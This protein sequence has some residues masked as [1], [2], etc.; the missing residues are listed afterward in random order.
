MSTT[1]THNISIK[2]SFNVNIFCDNRK[3][4]Y[5]YVCLTNGVA[6]QCDRS[7]Q[8]NGHLKN[9]QDFSNH[10]KWLAGNGNGKTGQNRM[11]KTDRNSE[12]G[13]RQPVFLLFSYS[14]F[15]KQAPLTSHSTEWKCMTPT[16]FPSF[17]L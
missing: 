8:K 15:M 16:V 6:H 14:A 17:A 5:T 13:N 2:G 4:T 12:N 3:S 1:N 7:V 10:R 11:A 9:M